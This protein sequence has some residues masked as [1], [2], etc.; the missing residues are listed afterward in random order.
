MAANP[1]IIHG[2]CLDV[3]DVMKP[4]KMIFADPPDN[5][6]LKY[7]G[8]VDKKDGY[9]DWLEL[10][11]LRSLAR[12]QVFWLSYYWQHDLEIKS[13]IRNTLKYRFPAWTAKTF[14]WRYTFGQYN[15]EDC[16]SGFRFLL[17]CVRSGA[18][19]YPDVLRIPS[20]RMRLGDPRAAGPRVPDDVWEIPRV[21]G[22]ASE[23]RPWHPTQHPEELMERIVR[24]SCSHFE[25][26]CDL[27]GGTG[28]TLR[29][30][31]RLGIPCMSIELSENYCNKQAS[32]IGLP[33]T[34]FS[35]LKENQAAGK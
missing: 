21:V 10:V 27:F 9:Y 2:D 22:N 6:G 15:D 26:C 16:G 14:I 34:P 29:V 31:K 8:Y 19:L 5:L 7:D 30:C 4:V 24:F 17:R 20:E 23:R 18:K 1:V 12:C 11:I 13:V 33:V 25:V 35:D 3:L 32:E 28:T